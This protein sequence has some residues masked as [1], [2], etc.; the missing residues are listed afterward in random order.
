[1]ENNNSEDR[2]IFARIAKA[3]PVRFLASGQDTECRAETTDIS[4]QGVGIVSRRRLAPQTRLEM[5]LDLPN[6]HN[7][8]YTRGEVVWS[9]SADAAEQRAGIRLDKAE[10]IGLAPV[11]WSH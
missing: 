8:F 6:S 10:L 1:M 2:R 3:L 4:A 11:L 5:W 9:S 7:P